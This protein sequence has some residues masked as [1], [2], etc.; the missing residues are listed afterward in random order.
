VV[1]GGNWAFVHQAWSADGSRI[2][3]QDGSG[4]IWVIEAD[5]SGEA[6]VSDDLRDE[7]IA[8]F[9]P[10]DDTIAWRRNGIGT[11]LWPTD[12]AEATAIPTY[13]DRVAWSPDGSV[14][15]GTA[16]GGAQL[17]VVDRAGTVLAEIEAPEQPAQGSFPSWQ[18]LAP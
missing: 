15:V 6:N 10:G 13:I 1:T 3:T 5:G 11:M 17:I 7:L 16:I 12:A 4:D 8:S 18:R 14:L 9:A 2:V